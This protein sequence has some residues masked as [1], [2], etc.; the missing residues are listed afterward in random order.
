MA[1]LALVNILCADAS[2]LIAAVSGRRGDDPDKLR[3]VVGFA[4][5]V[6]GLGD[7]RFPLCF[8]N[9]EQFRDVLRRTPDRAGHLDCEHTHVFRGR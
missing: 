6:G 5:A 9:H 2:G 1:Q 8:N 7:E 4:Q 3:A